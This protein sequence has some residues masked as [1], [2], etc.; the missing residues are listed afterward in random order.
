LREALG[1]ERRERR[2]RLEKTIGRAQCDQ[3]LRSLRRCTEN[4]PDR[5]AIVIEDRIVL[6]FAVDEEIPRQLERLLEPLVSDRAS[7]DVDQPSRIVAAV[8]A[9][10]SFSARVPAESQLDL[11]PV[12]EIVRRRDNPVDGNVSEAAD[13]REGVDDE[14]TFR[15]ALAFL[16]RNHHRT[17]AARRLDRANRG[18]ASGSVREGRLGASLDPAAV[19][20]RDPGRD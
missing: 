8:V 5:V 6:A 18:S 1:G 10:D 7:L 13:A 16:G 3:N 19:I 12:C 11:V 17:S 9:E 14:L 20:A 4:Q 2:R 15:L